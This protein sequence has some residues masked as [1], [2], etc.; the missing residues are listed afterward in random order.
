MLKNVNNKIL[1]PAIILLTAIVVLSF[2]NN[3]AFQLVM[4][5]ATNWVLMSFG[6]MFSFVAMLCIITLVIVYLSPF[7]NIRIGGKNATPDM[8]TWSW[9]AIV[10]CTTIA[11]GAVFW[12]YVQPILHINQPPVF[13]GMDPHSPQ[14]ITMSFATTFLQWSFMPYSIYAIPCVMFAFVYFNMRQPYGIVSTLTP[15]FGVNRTKKLFV[16]LSAVLMFTMILGMGSSLGQGMFS[17]SGGAAYLFGWEIGPSLYLGIGLLLVIPGIISSIT[18]ILKGIRILSDINVKIYFGIVLFVL[19]TGASG[20]VLNLGI[21]SFG[22]LMDNLFSQLMATGT[23]SNE[24]WAR[25]WLNYNATAWMATIVVA[26]IFLGSLCKGRTIKQVILVNFAAPCVFG[27][28]WMGI[29]G[30][31]AVYQ[32]IQSVGGMEAY[33]ANPG[34]GI[35]TSIMNNQGQEFIPYQ[36]YDTLPLP[37]ITTFFY[38]FSIVISFITYTDSCLTSMTTL[39]MSKYG[40]DTSTT[41]ISERITP[42]SV[43]VK[44][45]LGALLLLVTWSM[46]SYA[47]MDGAKALANL[48]GLAGVFIEVIIL[49]GLFK[50]MRKPNEYNYVDSEDGVPTELNSSKNKKSKKLGYSGNDS[51]IPLEANIEKS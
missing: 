29:L 25:D 45:L 16:P 9:F 17:L 13:W 46:V 35:I 12:A 41:L 19:I 11:T 5:S 15:T 18:G 6:G 37:A 27:I 42:T 38:L 1:W 23:A 31:N 28:I 22:V 49:V 47:S 4:N 39:C 20:F 34:G 7:G 10:L 40:E 43:F 24:S 2:V 44:V 21:E 33:L 32:D 3:D 8:N 30:G 48:G 26:P 50:I 51:G 14:A 36:F